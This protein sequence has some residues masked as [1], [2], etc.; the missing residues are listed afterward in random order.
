MEV[1]CAA[2]RKRDADASGL[3]KENEALKKQLEEMRGKLQGKEGKLKQKSTEM[4]GKEEELEDQQEHVRALKC[5]ISDKNEEIKGMH[6][7]PTVDRGTQ[8]E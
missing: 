8:T 6:L 1:F 3:E 5:C 7:T 4:Q 2:W